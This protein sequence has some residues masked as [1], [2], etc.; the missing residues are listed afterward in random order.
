MMIQNECRISF[1]FSVCQY[2]P[3]T[4]IAVGLHVNDQLDG[5]QCGSNLAL[6]NFAVVMDLPDSL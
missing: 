2:K 6:R 5:R 1:R 3:L 4:S